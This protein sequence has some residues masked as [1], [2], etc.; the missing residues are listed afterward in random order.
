MRSDKGVRVTATPVASFD[1]PWAMT[2]LPDRSFLVT[3]KPGR[4][5]WVR[6]GGSR[7][8][9]SG[10]PKVEYA[11]QGG[12][13]D[14]VLHPRFA[15][16]RLVYLSFA[17]A[18]SRGNAGATVVRARLEEGEGGPRLAGLQK[19]WTQTPFASGRGHYS[20][21]MAFGP[22]GKLFITAG[23]RQ[24]MTPAQD[25]AQS[26]GKIVRL[27]DDGSVPPDNPWQDRGDLARTFWSTGHRNMLG[28]AFDAQG[29]LW[30][31]EM[32]PRH[33]DELNLIVKGRNYG[34]PLV[35]QGN[36]YSG[37][38][39]PKH[40]SRPEFEPPKAFWVPAISPAG[41]LIY[42]GSLFPG[43][44]GSAF[45]GGLS[46]RTLVRIALKGNSAREAERF[47]WGKRVREIEQGPEGALWVLEDGSGG[48]LLKLTPVR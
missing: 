17:A 39:I 7:V 18:D 5:F 15:S 23:D 40:A 4:L 11:G 47:S 30:A 29:R 34:W 27:N 22:D 2:F 1:R 8:Q 36:H 42:S 21:R 24:E 26:L 43:W 28:M 32:G 19:I 38:R 10:V 41:F 3:E 37:Q 16:N 44:R 9:V 33:G 12:L 35:S 48:R 14:V 45:A 13:G 20:H 25:F 31:H 6:P 46:S